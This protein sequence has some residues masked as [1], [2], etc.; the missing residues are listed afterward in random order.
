MWAGAMVKP[1]SEAVAAGGAAATA[2]ALPGSSTGLGQGPGGAAELS[3]EAQAALKRELQALLNL[4]SVVSMDDLR[5]AK[6][7]SKTRH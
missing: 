7:V 2:D 4:H 6:H 1:A 5:R 3:A